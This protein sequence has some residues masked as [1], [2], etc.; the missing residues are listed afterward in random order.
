M[1]IFYSRYYEAASIDFPYKFFASALACDQHRSSERAPL[2]DDDCIKVGRSDT[3]R[4]Q[5]NSASLYQNS[6]IQ[7]SLTSCTVGHTG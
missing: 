5:I 4:I 6:P 1:A 7:A 2:A 3:R